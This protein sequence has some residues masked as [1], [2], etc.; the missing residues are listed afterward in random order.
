MQAVSHLYEIC[1]VLA[2]EITGCQIRGDAHL[3]RWRATMLR[4]FLNV[5]K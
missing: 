3:Y 4:A 1:S 2:V 5:K